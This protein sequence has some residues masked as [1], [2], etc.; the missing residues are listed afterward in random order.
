MRFKVSFSLVVMVIVGVL[1]VGCGS[2]DSSSSGGGSGAESTASDG[3]STT[4]KG[5]GGGESTGQQESENEG[6][7]GNESKAEA[8]A[9]KE[10][11][12]PLTKTEFNTRVNEICIQVPPTYEEEVKKLEKEVG[13]KPSKAEL[14][15][16]A[17]I[18]PLESA[19]EQMEFLT[20]PAGEEEAIE[21]TT[22]A[23]KAAIE[24]VE[25]NPTS[26]LSGP[27]SPFAEFQEVTKKRGFETC[28]GL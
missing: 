20:P 3:T 23:L 25:E 18:P 11:E 21:E 22:S 2:S 15:L 16:K 24:G 8:E 4:A 13:K 7:A 26:E 17:A 1:L 6:E 10:A 28:S 12:K 9:K 27:K 19:L 14:N 5:D